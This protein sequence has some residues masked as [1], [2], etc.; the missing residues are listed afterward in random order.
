MSGTDHVLHMWIISGEI[1]IQMN[2]MFTGLSRYLE[3]TLKLCSLIQ[4]WGLV[5]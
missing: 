4:S 5:L 2:W 1:K 3:V